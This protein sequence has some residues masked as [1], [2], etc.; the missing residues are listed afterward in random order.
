[1]IKISRI[2][3]IFLFFGLLA[4]ALINIPQKITKNTQNNY[5]LTKAIC[6][7]DNY[8]E[9]YLI[10]CEGKE[11]KKLSPTGFSIQKKQDWIDPRNQTELCE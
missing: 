1:M 9:D 7:E 4:L 5:T 11:I 3:L 2:I 10:E 8:C 6:D